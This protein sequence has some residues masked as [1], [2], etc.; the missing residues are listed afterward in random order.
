[1]HQEIN[2]HTERLF[3]YCRETLRRSRAVAFEHCQ[4]GRK[5][6]VKITVIIPTYNQEKY[7]EQC[8]DSVICQTLTDIEIFCV[9]VGSTDKSGEILDKYAKFDQRVRVVHQ[10]NQGV[11]YSRN[12]AIKQAKGKYVIFMDPDDFYPDKE[13]LDKLYNT[14]VK[15]KAK[16]CGGS[17]SVI[18]EDGS[19][20]TEFKGAA[21]GYQFHSDGWMKFSDYQFN[22]GYHRFLYLTKM[23]LDN[24]IFFPLLVR[25]QDPPFFVE[26]MLTAGKF[27]HIKDVVYRYRT[28]YVGTIKWTPQ[29]LIDLTKGVRMQLATCKT[30]DLKRL[31]ADIL[32]WLSS[33]YYWTILTKYPDKDTLDA[34]AEV[35][36]EADFEFAYG[37]TAPYNINLMD[38]IKLY[39]FAYNQH[40]H[41]VDNIHASLSWKITKPLR[42]GGRLLRKIKRKISN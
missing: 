37:I 23:L 25:Y 19:L 32:D 36:R 34:F 4:W 1:V 26:A 30:H 16:I 35:Y 15:H 5:M 3:E 39:N 10:K 13:V 31:Y 18:E 2:Q 38:S 24:K 6:S 42:V 20:T 41:E 7:V 27:Y 8:L 40:A 21:S 29:K 12:L 22:T 11:A 17:F 9:N 28:G 33:S 14:A